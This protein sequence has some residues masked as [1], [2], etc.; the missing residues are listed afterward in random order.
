MSLLMELERILP[1][2]FLHA[3]LVALVGGGG[4]TSLMYSLASEWKVRGLMV[5][6]TTTTAIR[7]PRRETGRN[8]D[9]VVV[10]SRLKDGGHTGYTFAPVPGITVYGSS[11][12][13]SDGKMSGIS[14]DAVSALSNVYGAVVVE[15]DGSRML[16]VKAPDDH[17]PVLPLRISILIG[18]IGLDCLGRPMDGNTVH[19]PELF[20]KVSGCAPGEPIQPCHL[21]QLVLS[22]SGLFK[23]VRPGTAKVLVLNKSDSVSADVLQ[24]VERLMSDA[25][26][27]V[28]AAF[29]RGRGSS[30]AIA[31][32]SMK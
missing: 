15:A 21:E 23:D 18:V 32:E 9:L 3:P 11:V 27:A 1:D 25:F 31:Q 30:K 16:P 28:D 12:C 14:V 24:S 20:A 17:E 19:R 26:Y 2:V 29:L 4:K 22:P 8:V 5:A 7:D 10:D 13:E 6:A